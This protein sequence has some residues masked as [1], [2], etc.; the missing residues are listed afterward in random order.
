M[1]PDV[2]LSHSISDLAIT[3]KICEFFET[4]GIKCWLAPRDITPGENPKDSIA[5][6]IEACRLMILV[7]S[8]E[9]NGSEE[10]RREV[11]LAVNAKKVLIPL[12]IENISPVGPIE[13]HFQRRYLHDAFT[14]PLERHLEELAR[15]LKPLTR[16]QVVKVEED[17]SISR[18]LPSRSSIVTPF[19]LDITQ[20]GRESDSPLAIS[21]NF[22][23]L[24]IVGCT[25]GFDL[26]VENKGTTPL[27]QIEITLESRVLKWSITKTLAELEAG[28]HQLFPA[29][30]EPLHSGNFILQIT[31]KW[32]ESTKQFAFITSR[33][34]RVNEARVTPDVLSNIESL[35]QTPFPGE[36]RS[37]SHLV[38]LELPENFEPL[39]LTLDYE[40]STAALELVESYRVLEIPTH[41]LNRV[42]EGTLLKME[43]LDGAATLPYQEIR[44]VARPTF[45]L[46]RSREESDFLPWFWPRN[47]IHDIKTRRI[48]KKQCALTIDKS[49]IYLSNEAASSITYFDG[50]NLAGSKTIA[51]E[52]RGILNLSGIYF[53]DITHLSTD[54]FEGPTISNLPHSLAPG[55]SRIPGMK[56][57][58][59]FA[60][61]T[62]HVLPQHSTWLFTEATFGT[63]RT[64][65]MIL[66]IEGLE[67][68]Q[69]RFHHYLGVFWIENFIANGAVEVDGNLVAP[70]SLV[71]LTGGQK[72]RLGQKGFHL[73]M[74]T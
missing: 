31:V 59:R 22:N 7:F 62:P 13:F 39:P 18:T 49:R 10:V 19:D 34:L 23:H 60:A 46:G 33:S 11:N 72:I 57:S 47:E 43:P 28:H 69:G 26:K 14:P 67:E 73:A 50:E 42:R 63:S 40:V 16:T 54:S 24:I 3:E 74:E 53:L 65:S 32:L 20:V 17:A 45:N 25:S 56:G 68:I 8:Q 37:L 70:G 61:T 30:V 29:D 9:A 21:L 2:F 15:M 51:L 48:S 58:V 52:H 5:K 6:G 36:D 41:F 12:R 44:L 71:P 64:N 1:A 66:D 4:R 38:K 27:H 35:L 55:S